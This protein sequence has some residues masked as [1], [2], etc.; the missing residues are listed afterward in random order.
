M[1]SSCACLM[2][3]AGAVHAQG[4]KVVLT[5]EGADEALAGYAWFKTQTIRDAGSTGSASP[6]STRR[7]AALV[8]A[9][10]G[11]DPAHVPPRSAIHGVRTAQQDVYDLMAQA[12]SF[13]YSRRPVGRLGRP[14]PP[15][16]DLDITNDRFTRWDPLNQSLYVGYKV[17][18][19]G[20]LAPWRRATAWP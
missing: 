12:T 16:D 13:V 19:A 2:R 9:S 3:L 17:M 10:M 7:S 20:P 4:Y 14:R 1:D 18:L 11:G 5:G 15:I 8:L 6:S